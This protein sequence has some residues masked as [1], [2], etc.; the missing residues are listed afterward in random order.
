MAVFEYL[1]HDTRSSQ[2]LELFELCGTFNTGAFIMHFRKQAASQKQKRNRK[3]NTHKTSSLM[4]N[5][6]DD[7]LTFSWPC[8]SQSDSSSQ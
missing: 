8:Q 4:G 5:Y 7:A 6:C 2:C 1:T 3:N